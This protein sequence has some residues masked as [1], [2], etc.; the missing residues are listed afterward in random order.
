MQ[1]VLYNKEGMCK[2]KGLTKI[3]A[4]TMAA[5]VQLLGGGAGVGTAPFNVKNG[6]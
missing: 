5:T 2:V 6:S 1:V 3:G 4:M